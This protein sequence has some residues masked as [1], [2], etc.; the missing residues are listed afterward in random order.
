MGFE[1]AEED[2]APAAQD[3]Q[4]QTVTEAMNW[5]TEQYSEYGVYLSG[6]AKEAAWSG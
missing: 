1:S 5:A 3:P 2:P 6:Q 4:F